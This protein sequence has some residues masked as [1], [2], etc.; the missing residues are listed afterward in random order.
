MKKLLVVLAAGLLV[1][2]LSGQANAL[3][4]AGTTN[5]LI[6]VVFEVT[7]PGAGGT[8]ST[9]EEATDLGPV[10]SAN[11]LANAGS[12][13]LTQTGTGGGSL[14]L[15][16]LGSY[17]LQVAYFAVNGSSGPGATALWTSGT[18]V[19]GGTEENVGASAFKSGPGNAAL[20]LL[21]A[22]NSISS[23]SPSVWQTTANL[24]S[25]YTKMDYANTTLLGGFHGF[26][27]TGAAD[28]EAALA[29][30]G[31]ATQGLYY[32]NP[33]GTD[34]GPIT[35]SFLLATSLSSS[36]VLTTTYEPL[37]SPTPIPPSV[38]LFGSGL[39]GLIGIKR[40]GLFNC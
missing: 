16:S 32:W 5:D 7:Q 35:A 26:L 23:S 24:S 2:G 4:S 20:S 14:S 12:I 6:R 1:V 31:T 18:G 30:G 11:T 3:W 25:Y 28:G 9:Y 37:T 17:G 36:G 15:G 13:N 40:R 27:N 33:A 19:A 22:Y 21:S 39:L 10:S 34:N 29:L 38:L 8:V